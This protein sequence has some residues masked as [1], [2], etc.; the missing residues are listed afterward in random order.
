MTEIYSKS[1]QQAEIAFG[2]EQSQFFAK[3]RAA[4]EQDSIAMARNEK[5]SRLR[6]ARLAKESMAGTSQSHA[7]EDKADAQVASEPAPKA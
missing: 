7:G 4:E 2:K 6:E 5:T 3:A 1:R